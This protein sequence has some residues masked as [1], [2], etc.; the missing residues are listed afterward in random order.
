M[1]YHKILSRKCFNQFIAP[2]TVY[3]SLSFSTI[4]TLTWLVSFLIFTYC[5]FLNGLSPYHL[6]TAILCLLFSPL[7]YQLL[8]IWAFS[9]LGKAEIIKQEFP[10]SSFIKPK[11]SLSLSHGGI[12]PPFTKRKSLC[13]YS[14]SFPFSSFLKDLPT[15]LSSIVS[16]TLKVLPLLDIS[17]HSTCSIICH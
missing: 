14:G 3:E 4:T 7:L 15:L 9:S 11:T 16:C 10:I 13:Q 12:V 8:I 2:Q 1:Q 5:V 6:K 17:Y